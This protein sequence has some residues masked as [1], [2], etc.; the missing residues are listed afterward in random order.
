MKHNQEKITAQLVE[1]IK[2]AFAEWAGGWK[3]YHSDIA[4]AHDG[5]PMGMVNDDNLHL[6]RFYRNHVSNDPAHLLKEAGFENPSDPPKEEKEQTYFEFDSLSYGGSDN[7]IPA[8]GQVITAKVN[9]LGKATVLKYFVE[10]GFIGLIV[11][12]QDPPAWYVK[13]NGADDPCHVFPSEY[14]VS[15]DEA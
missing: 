7:P 10:H 3:V 11:Q 5:R 6:F 12:P 1:V 4:N 9:G 2:R 15:E 13:Q 8:V 14:D